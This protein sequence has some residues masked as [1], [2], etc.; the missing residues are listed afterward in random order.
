MTHGDK[1]VSIEG[2]LK[3]TL[4]VKKPYRYTSYR[5]DTGT[6]LYYL[7]SRYYNPKWERFINADS[8]VKKLENYYLIICLHA[9]QM[10]Q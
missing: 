3:D 2:S 9:V 5:Y 10:T 7:Q 4:G 1:L 8:A 6:G